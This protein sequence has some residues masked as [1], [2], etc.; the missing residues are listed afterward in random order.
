MKS[1]V[2]TG[3]SMSFNKYGYD[4]ETPRANAWDCHIGMQSWSFRLCQKFIA[5]APGFKYADD[6]S[7]EEEN[8]SGIGEAFHPDDA[9]FGNR[10]KTIIPKNDKIHF[11]VE[12]DTDT[13]VIYFQRRP[14]NYCK[15]SISADGIYHN[16][17]TDTCAYDFFYRGWSILTVTLRC[18][19]N[20][21]V[22]E[23]VLSDF[24]YA[25]DA[26][27]VS[28]AGVSTEPRYAVTTGQG[29]RTAKFINYHFEDRIARFS[30]DTLILI[31]GGNDILFYSPEEYRQNLEI[32]FRTMK[33][34]FKNCK[35]FT[36][37]IPPSALYA[38]TANGIKYDTQEDWDE[39]QERYNSSMRILSEKYNATLIESQE[40]FKEFPVEKWRFDNVHLSNFGNDLLFNK[41]NELLF[42]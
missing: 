16:D 35:I 11:T 34:R 15:F 17:T 1:L 42:E 3:D 33:K 7:F 30:P 41:L 40:L 5:S 36:V 21:R 31:F 4:P 12:S 37:T 29:S 25:D 23:I 38:D 6:L 28:I 22:H 18:N 24:E 39:N 20:Q 19:K 27:M 8:F 13:I 26:P 14:Q 10:V 9:I 32:F 2:I